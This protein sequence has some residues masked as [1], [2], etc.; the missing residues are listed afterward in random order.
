MSSKKTAKLSVATQSTKDDSRFAIDPRFAKL[1]SNKVTDVAESDVDIDLDDE[2][3]ME[4]MEE[5]DEDTH[6]M[7]EDE[8]LQ[9]DESVV[10]ENKTTKSAPAMVSKNVS[11][12][13]K[14]EVK[15]LV[16][17]EGVEDEEEEEDEDE[18]ALALSLD[19]A[20]SI[21]AISK[22]LFDT[23]SASAMKK[24]DKFVKKQA[25]KGIAYLPHV[26]P[27]MRPKMVR[28]LLSH[29]GTI[30]RIYMTPEDAAVTRRRKKFNRGGKQYVDA[31]VEFEDKRK[32]KKAALMLNGMQIGGSARSR[33]HHD[34]WAIRYLS[35]FKWADLTER[36]SHEKKVR[37]ASMREEMSMAQKETSHYLDR[38]KEANKLDRNKAKKEK[39]DAKTSTKRMID[40]DNKDMSVQDKSVKRVKQSFHQ[41]SV[42][43]GQEDVLKRK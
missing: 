19:N 13:S 41:R 32:A 14:N 26:P 40:N 33:F 43:K 5:D 4:M 35:G 1:L 39:E 25:M 36:V 27:L 17:R 31:W 30:E 6:M 38:V 24:H 18:D 28:K 34:L 10:I 9:E 22:P 16:E 11:F 8:D 15:A 21:K 3:D 12:F 2:E 42:I 29:F 37:E 7:E 20:K 23:N